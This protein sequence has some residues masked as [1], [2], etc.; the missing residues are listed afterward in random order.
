[1]FDVDVSTLFTYAGY[2]S[3]AIGGVFAVLRWREA[4][5]L[6]RMMNALTH[7][8]RAGN[9][10]EGEAQVLEALQS[11]HEPTIHIPSPIDREKVSAAI[12]RLPEQE[13]LAV[14]LYY[15]KELSPGEIGQ[16]LGI[17]HAEVERLLSRALQRLRLTLKAFDERHIE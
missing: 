2:V 8:I 1:M 9:A 17:S 6:K 13:K 7:E 15:Y 10:E 12:A 5:E 4:R 14:T 16:V 3:G 11:K